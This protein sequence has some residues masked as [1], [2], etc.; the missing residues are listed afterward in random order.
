MIVVLEKSIVELIN[1]LM[2]SLYA[3]MIAP[4]TGG[5]VRGAAASPLRSKLDLSFPPETF[6]IGF[7]NMALLPP[8]SNLLSNLITGLEE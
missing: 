4:L 8:P 3:Y 6:T 7:A 2:I 1:T 5:G